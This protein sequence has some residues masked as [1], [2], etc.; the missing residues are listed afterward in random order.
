V[1]HAHSRPI[2]AGTDAQEGDPVAMR[3]V[4]VRLDLEH[5]AAEL[6]LAGRDRPRIRCAGLRRRRELRKRIEQLTDTVIVDRR[7]EEHGR[8]LASEVGRVI[9]LRRRTADELDGLTKLGGGPFADRGRE[10]RAAE[11]ADLPYLGQPTTVAALIEMRAVVTQIVD[12]AKLAAHADRPSERSTANIEHALDVVEQLYAQPTV[13]VELVDEADDRGSPQPA[14]VHE[15]DRPRFDALRGID[16]HQRAIDRRQ[17]PIRILGEIFV[18]RR[19]EQVDQRLAVR[20]LHDRRR[21]R[22]AAL[23]LEAHPVGRCVPGRLAPLHGARHLNRPAEQQQLLGQRGLTRVGVR[24]D[25]ERS[26][27]QVLV[28]SGSVVESQRVG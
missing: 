18:T 17:R 10:L 22:Y 28:H 15:L 21:D 4:H 12:A 14:H 2:R 24:N 6:V 3:G 8:L 11:P 27:F 1:I 13:A 16:D 19:V 23:L 25:R 26:P 5:E 9:E 20:K 7:T